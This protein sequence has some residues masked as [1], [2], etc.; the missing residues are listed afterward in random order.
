MKTEEQKIREWGRS[1]NKR[2]RLKIEMNR[3]FA[4]NLVNN[5]VKNDKKVKRKK[6]NK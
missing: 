3:N 6:E 1:F 4:E 5:I 2:S